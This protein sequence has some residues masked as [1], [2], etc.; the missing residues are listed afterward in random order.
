MLRFALDGLLSFSPAPVRL[1]VGAG[2]AVTALSWAIT[3]AVALAAM[4]FSDPHLVLV[5]VALA[6]GHMV[7]AGAH[8]AIGVLGEYAVRIYE[9]VKGRPVYVLKE[10]TAV[11]QNPALALPARPLSSRAA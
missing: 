1:A 8:L 4:P 2:L 10:S 6:G 7:A 11:A 9:Q 3:S 5:L